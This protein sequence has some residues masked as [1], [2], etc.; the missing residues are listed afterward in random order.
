MHETYF[1][2]LDLCISREWRQKFSKDRNSKCGRYCWIMWTHEPYLQ[3][4]QCKNLYLY[5]VVECCGRV[6][7]D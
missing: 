7:L 4:I 2:R 1:R 6:W 5:K 3:R